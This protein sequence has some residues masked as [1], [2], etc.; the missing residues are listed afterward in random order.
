MRFQ[1][2]LIPLFLFLFL[3]AMGCGRSGNPEVSADQDE[4]SAYLEE[5]GD[6]TELETPEE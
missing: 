1:T 5:H 2:R 4:L 3:F 6:D